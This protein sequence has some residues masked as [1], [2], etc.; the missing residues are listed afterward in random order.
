[1][2]RRLTERRVLRWTAIAAMETNDT[3]FGFFLQHADTYHGMTRA[4]LSKFDP[5]LYG[6][7]CRANQIHVA[8]P[9]SS[10]QQLYQ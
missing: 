3:Q 9:K 7:L 10:K 4:R 1:M 5:G 2:A 8:I 6:A